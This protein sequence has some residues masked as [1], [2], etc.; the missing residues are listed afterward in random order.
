LVQG[1]R[2]LCLSQKSG[3][4]ERD[5]LITQSAVETNV[6]FLKI[7]AEG[8]HY[9]FNFSRNGTDWTPLHEKVDG[10]FLGSAGAGRFTGT[11]IG[12]YASSNGGAGNNHADIDWFEYVGLK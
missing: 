12:M 2:T 11:M 8:V 4:G 9:S 10:R 3:T 5:S 1:K 7:T 6:Q